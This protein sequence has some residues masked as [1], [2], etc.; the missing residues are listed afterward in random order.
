MPKLSSWTS[1]DI[2]LVM[3]KRD[4]EKKLWEVIGSEMNRSRAACHAKW[5]SIKNPRTSFPH[6]E[7]IVPRMVPDI[8][9]EHDRNIRVNLAPRDLTAAFFGDPLPGYSVLDKRERMFA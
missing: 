3:H 7:P 5:D 2:A 9:A 4:V 8:S 6:Q 1:D